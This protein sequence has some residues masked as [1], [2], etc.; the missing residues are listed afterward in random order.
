[1]VVGVS[2]ALALCVA[3]LAGVFVG[4]TLLYAAI[5]LT[6]VLVER[7]RGIGTGDG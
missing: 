2:E 6:A 3:G 5:R 4:M 7:L 1:V